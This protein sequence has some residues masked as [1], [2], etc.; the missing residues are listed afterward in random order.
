[1]S[2]YQTRAETL[3]QALPYIQR[4]SGKTI[5][6]KYGGSAMADAAL[7]AEVMRD[8]VLMQAVGIRTVLLHGG[9][10]E[11]D[12]LMERV[13]KK[14][15]KVAGMRVTDSE[16]MEL[17]EMA[18]AG[19]LNKGLVAGVQAAGG[20]AV[21]LSGKDGRLFVAEKIEPEGHDLGFVGEVREVNP[22]VLDTLTGA[23]YIPILCSDAADESGQSYTVNADL[24][25]G[26]LAAALRVEKLILMTDVEGVLRTYP[27]PKS[28]VSRMSRAEAAGLLHDGTIEKGML[29]KVQA[30]LSALDGG[31]Q[32]EH[33]I[34]GRRPHSLLIEV[35]T[36]AGIGTMIG[37]EA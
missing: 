35:F 5:V 25:A 23:G 9:G 2:V 32:S 26:A 1:M 34:D 14:P 17:V 36:D 3:I 29:P 21:G 22:E 31:A 37:G 13:G 11:I 24:A 18:L 16:T 8:L 19:S 10:P 15:Q 33:I 27:D 4:F 30:C 20:K 28:L 6:V 12:R 7:K